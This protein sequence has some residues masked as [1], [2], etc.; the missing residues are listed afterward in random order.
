MDYWGELS[1]L[2]DMKRCVEELEK[3]ALSMVNC[4]HRMC[5]MAEGVWGEVF[6]EQVLNIINKHKKREIE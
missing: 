1:K 3:W 4:S 2:H 6:G 5:S